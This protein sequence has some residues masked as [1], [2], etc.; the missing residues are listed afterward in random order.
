MIDAR[1]TILVDCDGVLV[2]WEYK[3][4]S[5]MTRHGYQIKVNAG[6]HYRI[7]DRF[8]D[9][10]HDE[11]SKLTR[12]FNESAAIL[13]MPPLRDSVY[14]VKR[15]NW[16]MGFRYRV[17]T[18]L[19]QDPDAQYLRRTNLMTLYGDIFD[20]IVCL[21][22]GSDKDQALKAYAGTNCWWIEDKPENALVG[23]ELGLRPILVAH[24]HNR[25]FD[26]DRVPVA[27]TW[28]QIYDIIYES[29]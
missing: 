21:D 23:L 11:S 19:S 24:G 26:H 3:F 18:S 15:L 10:D 27:E 6:D 16:K 14:W 12:Q 4:N 9:L 5:W 13:T 28:Q 25:E 17:I 22:T 1:T 2:D 8:H 20:D 7:C 29:A